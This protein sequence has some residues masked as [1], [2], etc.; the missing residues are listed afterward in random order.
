VTRTRWKAVGTVLG[1]A[2]AAIAGA[3]GSGDDDNTTTTVQPPPV[4]ATTADRLAK[5]SNRV[6]ENLDA[7]L[8]CDAAHAADDL[9]AAVE[10]SDLPANLRPGVE[11]VATDL[12]NQVNCPPPPPPPEPEPEEE[13]RDK[14]KQKDEG[15]EDKDQHGEE[16]GDQGRGG[17]EGKDES[18]GHGGVPPGQAKLK[19]EEG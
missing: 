14:E 18:P 3:C 15:D 11:T 5:L 10:E 12:V 9:S 19:G 8:T 7:G 13:K 6:A 17:D 1:F 4:S 16:G 2:L